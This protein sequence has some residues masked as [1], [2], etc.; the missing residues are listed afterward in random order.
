M[1]PLCDK[2]GINAVNLAL[3]R[4][5]LGIAESDRALLE[6]AIPFAERVRAE[7]AR[8]FVEEQF[9]FLPT[10]RFY[11]DQALQAGLSLT[12]LRG[13]IEANQA[14]YF[15]SL[16]TGAR[17]GW[18]VGYFEERL[19]IGVAHERLHV[20]LKWHLGAYAVYA[21]ILRRLLA[22]EFGGEQA[23]DL[24]QSLHK[25]LFLDMQAIA[26]SFMAATVESLGLDM[27]AKPSSES[28]DLT[29]RF[30][31]LRQSAEVLLRQAESVAQGGLYE[32][33]MSTRVP[34]RLGR[35][36]QDLIARLRSVSGR[37]RDGMK[38]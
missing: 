22:R 1:H 19:R 5:Y 24:L 6:S 8:A 34:G 31:A 29:D 20:P 32:P 21:R 12:D 14:R 10:A 35:A 23:A 3:R 15:V 18:G 38:Q 13:H 30:T 7:F 17:E 36:C 2:L 33:H 11:S 37:P 25:V 27:G 9:A 28:E 4:Q 26:D 16:F